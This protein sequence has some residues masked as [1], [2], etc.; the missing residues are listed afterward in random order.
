MGASVEI[1]V[2]SPWK[3]RPGQAEGAPS[4]D[5]RLLRSLT[6]SREGVALPLPA[7]RKVRAL[8]AYLSLAPHPVARSQLCELLWDVP[9]D[10]RGE[11][12][13]C[14][15]KIRSVLDEPS[16]RRVEA[17]GDAVRLDL[18]DCFVDAV[19]IARA[20]R[21]GVKALAP[22]RLRALAGLFAGDFLEG[23]EID[24]NPGFN[25]WLVAQRRR[26][27]DL[28]AALLEHLVR[29]VSEDELFGYLDQWLR[30][31]PFDQRPHEVLLNALAR[32][33]RVREGDEHLVATARLFEAEG[34][35]CKPLG[36]AWRAA[37]AQGERALLARP[38]APAIAAG[39]AAPSSPAPSPGEET[40]LPLP[41]NPSIA[42]LPFA[43]TSGDPEQEYFA[44]GM[45]EDII[46]ELSR[47]SAFFVV[48]RNSSF[49][50]RG[51]CFD[52][53]QVGRELGVRYIVE[54]SVRQT[55]GRVR[56]TVNLIEAETGKNVWSERYDRDLS[57]IFVV[58]DE[59]TAGLVAS[60]QTQLVLNEGLAAERQNRPDLPVW[61]LA[62]RGL[63]EIYQLTRP[64]L[65]RALAI[66]REIGGL[67]P[68]SAKGHQ[69]VALGSYHLI[70]M[71]FTDSA[72]TL[73]D[74][75]FRAAREAVRYDTRDEYSQWALGM[76]LGS[77]L[78]RYDEAVS[79]FREALRMNPN[80]SLAFA[81]LGSISGYACHPDEAIAN[82][83]IAIRLNPRDPSLFF[84]Y[85]TL[86]LAHFVKGDFVTARDWAQKS[87]SSK[88]EWWLGHAL[89]AASRA[90]LEDMEGARE[91]GAEL[92][93]LFPNFSIN[94]LPFR[95]VQNRRHLEVFR[96]GLRKAGLPDLSG[97]GAAVISFPRVKR[98]A[99]VQRG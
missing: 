35:D 76:V 74:E 41:E 2:E 88:S 5:V 82:T 36:E 1:A 32:R 51:R 15:S 3:N 47:I 53:K 64:S 62:K 79:A 28:H 8:L 37:R 39:R 9:N 89:R 49:T 13:W 38:A 92:I 83:E 48:A 18:S 81:S 22:E 69:L 66:G 86:S 72:E 33:G 56:L 42:V 54:G 70:L 50:Y 71:G 43:N 29:Q 67:D 19:E 45:A 20:A 77:L 27:R 94:S 84:R 96:A 17:Q 97:G 12:R 61:D 16:R 85:S 11:L 55:G 6:I 58:Q 57:D 14:L 60:M 91:A 25:G 87:V 10:P 99:L 23:L 4:L 40:L 78:G 68:V 95:A 44:E 80:F 24:R 7:S 52:L 98:E 21:E 31:A 75:A 63:K 93:R 65:E 30:L 26:F 46:T 59:I 90:H 73:Q 34:L